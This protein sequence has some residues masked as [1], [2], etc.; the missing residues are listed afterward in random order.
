MKILLQVYLWTRKSLI[1]LEVI[2]IWNLDMDSD[3]DRICLVEGLCCLSTLVQ[4]SLELVF[5]CGSFI[6]VGASHCG[7]LCW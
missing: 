5:Q 3:P 2:W 4:F 7:S 6:V 1:I